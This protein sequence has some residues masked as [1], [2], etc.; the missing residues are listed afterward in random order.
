M[1][2]LERAR[3]NPRKQSKPSRVK[4]LV[5]AD[6]E[7]EVFELAMEKHNL[8]FSELMRAGALYLSYNSH[9]LYSPVEGT[10]NEQQG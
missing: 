4:T 6:A 8:S 2:L 3:Y 5:V 10:V 7:L 9:L 1:V